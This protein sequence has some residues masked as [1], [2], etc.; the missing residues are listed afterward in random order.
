MGT[1]WGRVLPI[2]REQVGERSFQTW[3]EPLRGVEEEGGIRLEVP[4][5]FHQEWISRNFLLAI[6]EALARLAGAPREVRVVICSDIA[7]PP[8]ARG[9][10]RAGDG[11]SR[12]RR[13]VFGRLVATHTFS[14]LVVGES[15]R[16][17]HDAARAVAREPGREFNPLFIHGGVGLGKTHL[18]NA[19]AHEFLGRST[20]QRIACLAAETFMN[21]LITCL[22]QDQMGSFR[23]RFRNLDV[24]ILDDVQ[25]LAGKERTQ[26][27]F[28][29]TFNA[30]H[31]EGRQIVLTSD[32]APGGIKG[33]EQRLRSRFDG[34][35]TA[36]IH[37]PT[38]EMRVAIAE[39]K[40]AARGVDLPREVAVYLSQR[41]GSSVRELEGA[42]TRVV[43]TAA[44][45]RM[46]ITLALAQESLAAYGAQVAA[47]SLD[48]IIEQVSIEFRVA[49]A[50]LKSSGRAQALI[51]PRHL[52]MYLCRTL[53]L[54][55]F[56][57]IGEKLGGRDHS[58]VMHAVRGVERKREADSATA[59]LI[60]RLESALRGRAEAAER[61]PGER[62]CAR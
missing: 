50:D 22:R 13:P 1:I 7:T 60:A 21:N 15:N 40:A 43:A 34:G 33:L 26:E 30:L 31:A 17:A 48:E 6:R 51:L 35:L 19:V 61:G 28:F 39:R 4:S 23:Q 11:V 5:R 42:L 38:Y 9:P 55:S 59:S 29:H 57:S 41:V 45:R 49:P 3:I 36:Y 44:L 52:A 18:V 12:E 25:F 62:R 24:L 56:A 37:P 16:M 46:P 20:R 32:K 8:P 53:A 14:N 47:L 27:E 58:T 10:M 54:A 2:L